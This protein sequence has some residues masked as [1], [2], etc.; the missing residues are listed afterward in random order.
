V[1]TKNSIIPQSKVALET[2]LAE[3]HRTTPISGMGVALLALQIAELENRCAAMRLR[4]EQKASPEPRKKRALRSAAQAVRR[5]P[6]YES[7][8]C[9]ARVA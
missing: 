6:L 3:L 1:K 8:S 9:D 2:W 4:M 5:G 7:D